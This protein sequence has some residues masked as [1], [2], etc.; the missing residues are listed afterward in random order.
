MTPN[1][2]EFNSKKS[3]RK[4]E[5]LHRRESEQI[6]RNYSVNKIETKQKT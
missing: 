3:S 4:M 6:Q 2:Q 1:V 5:S